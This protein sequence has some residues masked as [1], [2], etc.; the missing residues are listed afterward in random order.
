Y[1]TN[2]DSIAKLADVSKQTVY[3]HFKT[4]DI[5]FEASMKMKCMENQAD[6]AIFDP[7]VSI[8]DALF[9]FGLRLHEMLLKPGSLN[10][11][12]N[13]VSNVD[14][15]PEFAQVY[16]RFGPEQTTQVLQ[17]YLEKKVGDGTIKLELSS[18]DTAVQLLLMFH[19]Q[20]VYWRYLGVNIEQ[21]NE[22]RDTYLKS[23]VSMFLSH[24]RA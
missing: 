9:Q 6:Q 12:R 21:S 22:Q 5:L 4:K 24:L 7:S 2:M 19:G 23:C 20:S 10:T 8:E 17:E 18:H 1:N 13:A 11:Y 15:H 3:S 14:S 16:L